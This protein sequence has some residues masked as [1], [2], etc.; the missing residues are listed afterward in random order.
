MAS[1]WLQSGHETQV[2]ICDT[3]KLSKLN[4]ELDSLILQNFR[5]SV[6]FPY[7]SLHTQVVPYTT[8]AKSARTKGS[9][10]HIKN[11]NFELGKAVTQLRSRRLLRD[12]CRF[13]SGR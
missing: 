5:G 12:N 6:I 2:Y 8:S 3:S 7:I 1:K 10:R 4:F 11:T 9:Q 13:F